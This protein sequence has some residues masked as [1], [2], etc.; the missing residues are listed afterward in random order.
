MWQGRL[1]TY[2]IRGSA[3]SGSPKCSDY[4]LLKPLFQ[5][6]VLHRVSHHFGI[7]MEVHLLHQTRLVGAD[8][9]VADLQFVRYFIDALAT[10]QR[11]QDIEFALRKNL[12]RL[13][14][15]SPAG[16]KH[17]LFRHHRIEESSARRYSVDGAHQGS[18]VAVFG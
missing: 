15:T 6:A 7:V 17:H 4:F 12:V 3:R 16:I 11:P 13:T 18:R 10:Y 2:N 14:F 5:Q 8:G 1:R 9:L